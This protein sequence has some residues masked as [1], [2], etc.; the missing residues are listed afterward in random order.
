MTAH[1]WQSLGSALV[2]DHMLGS[3]LLNGPLAS[4]ALERQLTAMRRR[5]LVAGTGPVPLLAHLAIQ[6]FLNGFVW[7]RDEDETALVDALWT[8][9]ATE[10]TTAERLMLAACYR[11]LA[12]LPNAS[13]LQAGHWPAAVRGV[14]NEHVSGPLAEQAAAA[15]LA[16]LTPIRA[17]VSE[18]VRDQYE[19]DPYPRWVKPPTIAPLPSEHL[20]QTLFPDAGPTPL[21][22]AADV[23]IAGCGTGRHAVQAARRYAGSKVLAVDL[24]R[25]SLGIAARRTRELAIAEV[26]YAQADL[27]ELGACGRTF[28]VIESLGVLH[29]LHDPFEGARVLTGLLRPGGA[30]MLALYSRTA[31][32][33]LA[34]AK[35]IARSFGPDR[36]GELRAA[37]LDAPPG[38]P[39][40]QAELYG[41]FYSASGCRDLLLHVQEHEMGLADIRRILDECGLRFLGFDL[42]PEVREAY[43][44]RFPDDLAMTDLA[45]WDAFEQAEP[46]TFIGMYQFWAQ[47]EPAGPTSS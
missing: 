41:D 39:A 2:N 17:G 42:A 28:D 1:D 14:L 34:A 19:T 5:C 24:S 3:L 10:P 18:T 4:P 32:R 8:R 43:R 35:A 30:M 12:A 27:L 16:V 33:G 9:L 26:E 11:S 29:H 21:P 6:G 31:R 13:D 40:H 46:R 47:K 22:V 45:N 44:A 36:I 7:R 38:D 15:G 20:L 37:I 23:L 25:A